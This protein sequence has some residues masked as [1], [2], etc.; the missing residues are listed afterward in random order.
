[1]R[2]LACVLATLVAVAAS[3]TPAGAAVLN[4]PWPQ[5]LPALPGPVGAQPHGVEHCPVPGAACVEDLERRLR[6]QWE[7]LDARCDHR[8]VAS[9][10][11]LRI[12]EE[13]RR[14][15][16]RSRPELVSDVPWMSAVITTFSNRYFASFAAAEAG[17][18]VPEAWAI[19]YEAAAR[20]DVSAAQDVLLFSNA[21]VQRDLP[22]AY[23]EMGLRT[24]AGGSHKPDHDAVNEVNARIFDG[25]QDETGYR[26][27]PYFPAFDAAPSPVDEI[28]TL[29]LVKTWRERAWRNAERLVAARS[30]AAR[31][32]VVADI[33]AGAALWARLIAVPQLPGYRATRDAHCGR[34]H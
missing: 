29:E 9:L 5:L 33:E 34:L 26:Y 6:A 11:Y 31:A 14:D 12:T 2:A 16:T 30:A 17:A 18:P 10:S 1:V 23:E 3:A 8:A 28:G 7:A 20:G 21:H 24:A 32:L 19:A 25:V 22:F 4:L 13:L 15:V 27:D